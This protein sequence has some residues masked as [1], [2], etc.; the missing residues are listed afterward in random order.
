MNNPTNLSRP[1]LTLLLVLSAIGAAKAQEKTP[2]AKQAGENQCTTTAFKSYLQ[3]GLALSERESAAILALRPTMQLTIER[4]RLQESF[5][6][7]FVQCLVPDVS[8]EYRALRQSQ[9]FETCLRDEVLEQYE[10]HPK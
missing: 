5:C 7:E 4:R 10:A 9:F 1:A 3:A 2:T 6:Q 8:P